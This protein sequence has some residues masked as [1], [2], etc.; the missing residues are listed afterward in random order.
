MLTERNI[1][2]VSRPREFNKSQYDLEV[3]KIN[4]KKVIQSTLTQEC[5][6]CANAADMTCCN[7]RSRGLACVSG[8]YRSRQCG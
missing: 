2:T 7:W 4:D 6:R 8:Q 5:I 3:I 1:A